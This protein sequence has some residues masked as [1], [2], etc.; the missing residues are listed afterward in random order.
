MNYDRNHILPYVLQIEQEKIMKQKI[1]KLN[2][3]PQYYKGV[4]ILLIKRNYNDYKAK[5]YMLGSRSSGQNVWIPNA[6]LE[7]DGTLKPNINIDFIFIK[8][9]LDGK[10]KKAGLSNFGLAPIDSN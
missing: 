2:L 9:N 8:A 6:Y 1:I 4:T 5:R 3:E 7:E 10:F